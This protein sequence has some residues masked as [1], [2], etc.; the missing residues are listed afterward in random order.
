MEFSPGL[1]DVGCGPGNFLSVLPKHAT[2]VGLD[3][4]L[5]LLKQAKG[6]KR[7]LVLASATYIP[8]KAEAFGVAVAFDVLE[9]LDSPSEALGEIHRVL[10]PA[11]ILFISVPNTESY[12]LKWKGREWIGYRDHTHKHLL[13]PNQWLQLIREAGFTVLEV[14][15][16]GLYDSPYFS[17]IPRSL[18]HVLFKVLFG[19]LAFV[20]FRFGRNW[21][22][23]LWIFASRN[24]TSAADSESRWS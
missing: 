4:N 11:G 13:S 8:F 7:S 23:N 6:W 15:T 20:G 21:G 17:R 9:H 16:D 2:S 5:A 22:E 10:R 14:R 3:N 12:G 1:L 18:Q 19:G 24:Q